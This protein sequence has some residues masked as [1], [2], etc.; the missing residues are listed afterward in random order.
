MDQ[1]TFTVYGIIEGQSC[2][3]TMRYPRCTW[4]GVDD[5]DK[6]F[7]LDICRSRFANW[8]RKEYGVTLTDEAERELLVTVSDPRSTVNPVH[9]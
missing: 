5:Y 9:P 1:L 8:A 3:L 2:I 7:L 4:D 6:G